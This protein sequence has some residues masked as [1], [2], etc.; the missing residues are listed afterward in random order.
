MNSISFALVGYGG[1]AKTHALASFDA[2]LRLSLPFTIDCCSIFSRRPCLT[3]M[4]N[5]PNYQDF[6]SMITETSPSFLDICTPNSA[7]LPYVALAAEYHLPVYCEKPLA[8]S[9][10]SAEKMCSIAEESKQIHGVSFMYRF[11]PAVH[12]LKQELQKQTIGPIIR[13]RVSLYHNTYLNP[14][15]ANAWR[16]SPES[17]GGALLDLGAH[18]IDLI[19]FVF[20]N[21]KEI[22]AETTI[23]FRERS[24]V[25]EDA[26]CHLLLEN[27]I[28]GSLEVSRISAET[29][30]RDWFEVYGEK[31]SFKIN[32]KNPY[33]LEYYHFET[34]CTTL[35]SASPALLNTLHFPAER[36]GLGFFQ[37]AHTAALIDFANQIYTGQKSNIGADFQDGLKVQQVITK[38]YQG[39]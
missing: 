5:V 39:K 20:G 37:S 9:L 4:K 14:E 29:N 24:F 30:N 36:A 21:I 11:I 2:N 18:S 34:N 16:C 32:M 27:G 25:D 31:G 12:L 22:S 17:G 7:H 26:F 10:A 28:Q 19:H 15:K 38:A 23:H 3:K 8:E 33:Q 13:F 35:L 6:S 1:I